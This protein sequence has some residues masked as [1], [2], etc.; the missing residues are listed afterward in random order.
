MTGLVPGIDLGRNVGQVPHGRDSRLSIDVRQWFLCRAH[1]TEPAVCW[2]GRIGSG[3]L[4]V[5][6][7]RC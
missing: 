1:A 4:A 7:R 3:V 2:V 5:Y 6:I